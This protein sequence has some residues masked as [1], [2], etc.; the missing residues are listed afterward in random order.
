MRLS[1]VLNGFFVFIGLV[2]A[3]FAGFNTYNKIVDLKDNRRYAEVG[4]ATSVAMS[5]TVAMSLERSVTQVSLALAD[6]TPQAF[7]D[8]IKDQRNIANEGLQSAIQMISSA[9]FLT[10]SDD[11]KRQSQSAIDSM[12]KL[13]KEVDT[14]L[15]Q[16]KSDRNPHRAYNVPYEIKAEVVA[17]RNATDL[18]R[19]HLAISTSLGGTLDTIQQRAWEVREFGG[20][21]RTYFAI[22]TANGTVISPQDL[23]AI[24]LDRQRAAEAFGALKNAAIETDISPALVAQIAQAERVYFQE[25]HTLLEQLI[26]ISKTPSLD[27]ARDYEISFDDFFAQSNGA[28]GMFEALSVAA[29]QELI[30]YLDQREKAA[31]TWTIVNCLLAFLL[32]GSITTIAIGLNARVIRKLGNVTNVLS[33][34]SEGN[35][36]ATVE[37]GLREIAEIKTLGS[38][39]DNIRLSQIALN[40]AQEKAAADAELQAQQEKDRKAAEEVRKQQQAEQEQQARELAEAERQETISSLSRSLG[41]VVS[42]ASAGDFS[43][44]VDADFKDEELTSLAIN[45]N[46]LVEGVE[47]GVTAVGEVLEKV[48]QGN[49]TYKMTGTHQGAFK[50]LQD[51]TN[52]MIMALKDLITGISGSTDNLSHSSSELR[53]T[54]DALSKQAEQNAAS[55]EETSAALEELSASIRQVDSNISDANSNAQVA[56]DTA[57]QGRIV[58][59]EA[60]EAMSRINEASSEISNVVNVINDISFQIN[61]LALNAGVEAAR[62]GEAGRGFSVV[63]SEV[64]SLAQRA[65]EA[66]GEIAT[67]IAKSDAAVTKGVDKVTDAEAS[68]QKISDSVI[69]VSGSIEDIARAISE[70]VNGVADINTAVSQIDQNT[71]KQAASF[72]EVTAASALLSNEAEG[73]KQ[74][75]SRFVTESNVVKIDTKQTKRLNSNSPKA[76]TTPSQAAVH[77][78]LA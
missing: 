31:I 14:M 57:K 5:A 42:A 43:K 8:I 41:V 34:V 21:A 4:Q 11:F 49:L 64:R 20:R 52:Q 36:E 16:P 26:K 38:A 70:Q 2:V 3:A 30:D 51:N 68:L 78:N 73:L 66:S 61:L 25:Y 33:D 1:V 28:L 72:E 29:G 44:R 69:D 53:D 76:Q 40:E 50:E 19:N 12:V 62:A 47:A 17:L 77:G 48:A 65:S 45:V 74:A 10:T 39:V 46:S 71:Q 56:S 7:R 35:L 23:V 67:V 27:A 55:L 32:V 6:P 18:L 24:N 60:A 22:A 59:S 9:E 13:R 54:S 58:A 63:A 15:A 37:I 75:S